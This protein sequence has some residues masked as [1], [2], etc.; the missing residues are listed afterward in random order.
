[1]ARLSECEA[2]GRNVLAFLD[3]IA[4][5]E[6]TDIPSQRSKDDGYDVL[7]GGALLTSYN[8]HPNRLVTLRPNLKSTAAGR[9]Q[10]LKRTWDEIAKAYRLADFTPENQDRAAIALLRRRKALDDVKAGRWDAAIRKVSKEWASIP[11]AGY[12]QHEQP[13]ERLRSAYAQAGGTFADVA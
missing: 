11:G 5:S 7:V 2:G 12:G 13:V 8:A 10:F 9:Y 6:G 3:M 4:V 1:M